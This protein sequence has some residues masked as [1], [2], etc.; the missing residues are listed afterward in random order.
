MMAGEYLDVVDNERA[1]TFDRELIQTMLEVV[2]DYM[3]V[4]RDA[5]V[6]ANE[7][8]DA[9]AKKERARLVGE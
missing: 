9:L 8:A 7:I 6:K 1:W 2:R 4:A 3:L 5:A